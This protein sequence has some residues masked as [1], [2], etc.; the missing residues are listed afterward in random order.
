[1][2]RGMS[3]S[4]KNNDLNGVFVRSFYFQGP[5]NVMLEGLAMDRDRLRL[6]NPPDVSRLVLSNEKS[7]APLVL[8]APAVMF[9]TGVL[10]WWNRVVR[11]KFKRPKTNAQSA[12]E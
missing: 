9:V 5:D 1:M 6:R 11:K 2:T 10:M 3:E 4:A 7:G 8:L 12:S